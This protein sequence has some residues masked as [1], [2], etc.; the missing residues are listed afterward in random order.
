VRWLGVVLSLALLAGGCGS[1]DQA[2][3]PTGVPAATPTPTPTASPTAAPTA[4]PDLDPLPEVPAATTAGPPWTSQDEGGDAFL[5]AVFDDAQAMWQREFDAAGLDYSPATITIFRD[6]V[7]TACGTQPAT[8]GP[9]YCPADKGV[10]L[11]RRFFTALS[12]TVGVHLGDFAQ[13]YV[14]AHEV[15]HHVQNELGTL[16][17]LA[18][19]D[20]QDPAGENARSVRLELQADCFAGIWKHTRYQR[21]QLR[22][23]DFADALRAAAVVGNDFGQLRTTGTIRPEEWTHGSSRQRQQWLTRGFEQGRPAACDTF[24]A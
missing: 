2:G 22:P 21:G 9:F 5:T 3:E 23:E 15:A 7:D 19:A 1:S 12:R 11:D 10:Y 17:W 4:E 20:A 24:A 14:V 8:V 18:M 16:K 6:E 13:A